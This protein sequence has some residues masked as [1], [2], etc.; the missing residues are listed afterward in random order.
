MNGIL[1]WAQ[2][3]RP[4]AYGIAV[5]LVGW[6]A[7]TPVPDLISTGLITIIGILLGTDVHNAVM[8]TTRAAQAI[9]EAAHESAKATAESLTTSNVGAAGTLSI[10]GEGVADRAAD[11]VARGTL[12]SVGINSPNH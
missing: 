1:A 9:K 5:V 11:L 12:K 4:R 10:V 7:L 8:P 2:N 6:L 3:N